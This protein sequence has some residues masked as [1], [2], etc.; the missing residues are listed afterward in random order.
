MIAVFPV[1]DKG[2][3]VAEVLPVAVMVLAL[4]LA[5][6]HVVGVS[7]LADEKGVVVLP[8]V[9]VLATGGHVVSLNPVWGVVGIDLA[10]A[11]LVS[12]VMVIVVQPGPELK[13]CQ[14]FTDYRPLDTTRGH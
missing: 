13:G 12:M 10:K 1:V 11:G 2:H 6:V 9:V 7:E 14:E 5:V 3:A 4:V 8:V